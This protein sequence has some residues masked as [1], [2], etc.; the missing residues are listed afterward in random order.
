[1]RRPALIV[2]FKRPRAATGFTLVELVA[3]LVIV[4]VLAGVAAPSLSAMNGTRGSAAARQLTRDMTFARQRAIATGTPS[5]VVFSIAGATWSV[6]AEDPSNPGRAGATAVT[7][8]ATGRPYT[9]AV[10]TGEYIGVSI[11]SASFAGQSEVGFDWLG[12]PLTSGGSVMTT[13]GTTTLTGGYGVIVHG[14]T[15]CVS[16]FGP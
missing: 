7:D 9:Q 16:Y 14:R 12:Q 6:L 4:A 5:W 3:V 15:G 10:S 2:P 13:Q 1:M 8:L 11:V